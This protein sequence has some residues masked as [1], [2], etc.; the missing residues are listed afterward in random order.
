MLQSA[1][2]YATEAILAGVTRFV[3][4]ASAAA[5][6]AAQAARADGARLL[7]APVPPRPPTV[8]VG[9]PER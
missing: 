7:G 8:C 6:A 9:C 1:G 2:E 3:D 5:L 4:G